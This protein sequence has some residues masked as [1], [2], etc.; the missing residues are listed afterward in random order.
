MNYPAEPFRIKSVETVSMIPRDE[1]LKKMQEAGYNTF[2]LNSKDIY[3]DLLTDSGTNAMSDKQWAGMMMGDEAYAGSENFYHLERTVQELFGFKHIVPTHQGRGAEN[4]LS[5][6]A[7]KPGQYV[8]GNMYFTTTRY[9]Q[10]KNGAVFVDIVRDEAHDAGLN[11]AFKGDIDLKKLQ[12]LI[13]EKGA[14]NIAYICLAV[15]VNLAGGQP[16]SMANMRA[17]RELT[18][19][20]GIKVF[21]DATRCVENAYFIKEQEQGFENKSIAEIVHEMFSYADGCTMSGKKDCLVNIGGFLCMNDDEMFSSAKELVVVYEGMPSYG[22]LAGRDMEAMA[23][24]LREAMQ[25]EYIE[26][27]VKQVRYLGDKLKAA[28]VPIVEPVGGH[29]VF[30]DARRFCEHLTQDEFPAQ[31]LAASIYVETGVRSMERGIISAGRNNVTG[32]HHRPKLETV[33][34]TIPRRVYTY[35]HMDVV[36][37][38]IIKLYQHKEDIRGLKFIY[39][40]KQLRF[41]TARFD[42]I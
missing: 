2:L 23:I 27:R 6:L 33:R 35:A 26:H 19:A 1:R 11:I 28:G 41:F 7:I 38:G 29:A 30:L 18:A 16:V 4:L 14:E 13:D 17:V 5:Q 9:H 42:Y 10:E 36:A 3:I 40:P 12:T 25:Y 32:E 24:G 20:H 37:D 22:G 8:A 39:E 31:S 21:Y 15:T 34:L